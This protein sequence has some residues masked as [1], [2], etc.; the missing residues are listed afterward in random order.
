VG[1]GLL[2]EVEALAADPRG[3]SRT[4]RQALGYK[5]LLAHV[6][7]GVDLEACVEEAVRR[8][9]AFARRQWSW[10][11]RDPRVRWVTP[12]EDPADVVAAAMASLPG[13]P[14]A[15]WRPPASRHR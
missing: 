4:A 10:H 12:G 9:R 8:T 5:E 1:D 6:E 15:A 2:G 14:G 3:L 7:D 13:R 11:R